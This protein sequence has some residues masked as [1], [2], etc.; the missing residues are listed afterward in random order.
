MY[1]K[2]PTN[3]AHGAASHRQLPNGVKTRATAPGC[4]KDI[5]IYIYIV[6]HIY[7]YTHFYIIIYI[8]IYKRGFR[9]SAA[10]SHNSISDMFKQTTARIIYRQNYMFI[11]VHVYMYIYIYIYIYI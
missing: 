10:I 6:I 7:I 9:R 11:V 1:I 2:V 8:Y 5:Y 3:A 4:E